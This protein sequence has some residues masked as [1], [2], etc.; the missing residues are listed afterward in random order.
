MGELSRTLSGLGAYVCA[1]VPSGRAMGRESITAVTPGGESM[2]LT[3]TMVEALAGSAPVLAG[4]YPVDVSLP[5][6][7]VQGE[8]WP[9][10]SA[11]VHELDLTFYLRSGRGMLAEPIKIAAPWGRSPRHTDLVLVCGEKPE[12]WP[13]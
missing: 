3:I 1:L 10:E 11:R 5:I 13:R 12:G 7:D 9:A 8:F 6:E 4:M 2:A